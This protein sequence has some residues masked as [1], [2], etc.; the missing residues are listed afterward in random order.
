MLV[1]LADINRLKTS[2]VDKQSFVHKKS[3]T[4]AIADFF[5]E[6]EKKQHPTAR[7]LKI[8]SWQTIKGQS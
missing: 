2:I 8:L 5:N 1:V 3:F 7:M 6:Q 4:M